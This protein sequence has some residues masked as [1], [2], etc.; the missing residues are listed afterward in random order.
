MMGR[1]PASVYIATRAGRW[2]KSVFLRFALALGYELKIMSY[3]EKNSVDLAEGLDM[4]VAESGLGSPGHKDSFRILRLDYE[5]K[6][7]V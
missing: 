3:D 1:G 4:I 6:T 7:V 5:N 2:S